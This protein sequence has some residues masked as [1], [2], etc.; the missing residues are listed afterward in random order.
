MCKQVR[1]IEALQY[2]QD[3][4]Q[5]WT[6]LKQKLDLISSNNDY[7]RCGESNWHSKWKGEDMEDIRGG[8]NCSIISLMIDVDISQ[9][10]PHVK[11]CMTDFIQMQ[12]WF[13]GLVPLDICY[14]FNFLG[15]EPH[16]IQS[17]K[18]FSSRDWSLY[19]IWLSH[20]GW[21]RVLGTRFLG[22]MTSAE[23]SHQH[24]SLNLSVWLFI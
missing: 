13:F 16:G 3:I 18:D 8:Q 4:I 20:M 12:L 24:A 14:Q 2:T 17:A 15:G 23:S 7:I 6:W 11:D 19:L 22:V 5:R 9:Q 10:Q 21:G 1:L